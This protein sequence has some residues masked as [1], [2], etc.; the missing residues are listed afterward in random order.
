LRLETPT[1]RVAPCLRRSR[2]AWQRVSILPRAFW[3]A[4]AE[5]SVITIAARANSTRMSAHALARVHGEARA[6]WDTAVG[7]S[8]S[9][10]NMR[11]ATHDITKA[12]QQARPNKSARKICNLK[13]PVRHAENSSG[14]WDR[15]RISISGRYG[16]LVRLELPLGI[17]SESRNTDHSH[18][19]AVA[20]A[21]IAAKRRS[22]R[23]VL[24]CACYLHRSLLRTIASLR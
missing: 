2:P 4:L 15:G 18:L 8:G 11:D 1:A 21:R 14:K 22:V 10:D 12:Q 7:R 20:A 13:V 24:G 19:A 5:A 6:M 23:T 3:W 9:I 17:G 16:L